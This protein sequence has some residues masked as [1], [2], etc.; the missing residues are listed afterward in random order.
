M[1]EDT[2]GAATV[3]TSALAIAQLQAPYTGAPFSGY[4]SDHACAISI[5]LRVLTPLT[6]NMSGPAANHS[7]DISVAYTTPECD[8]RLTSCMR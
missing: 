2:G 6:G 8:I 7:G 4:P 5:N 1:Y 3:C